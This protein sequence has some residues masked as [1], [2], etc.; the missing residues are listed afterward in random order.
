MEVVS[1]KRNANLLSKVPHENMEDMAVVYRFILDSNEHG[2][3]SILV[4]NDMIDH[5]GVSQEQLK[6]DALENAPEIRPAVIQGM[7]EV[8]MEMMGPEM[9][10]MMGMDELPPEVMYVAWRGLAPSA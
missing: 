3:S 9:F 6:A 1:A 5:M 8:M 7:N 4:T 10:E 2:R